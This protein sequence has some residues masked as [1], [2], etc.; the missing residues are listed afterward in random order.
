MRERTSVDLGTWGGGK[1]LGELVGGKV[2]S[3][4][5]GCKSTYFQYKE[6]SKERHGNGK[7]K[8]EKLS[9]FTM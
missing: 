9:T 7:Y 3:E 5:A 2:W 1:D 8:M 6:N 4:Y